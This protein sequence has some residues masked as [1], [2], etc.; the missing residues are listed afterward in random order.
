M[1]C[2]TGLIG[3]RT[4]YPMARRPPGAREVCQPSI[5]RS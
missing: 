5:L 1:F 3:K 4:K 2:V